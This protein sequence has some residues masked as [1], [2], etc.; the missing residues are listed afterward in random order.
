MC[1]TDVGVDAV[2]TPD[3]RGRQGRRLQRLSA[4]TVAALDG[5]AK[6]LTVDGGFKRTPL[7]RRHFVPF[8]TPAIWV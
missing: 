7:P 5:Q 4:V 1:L 8:G 3:D 6:Q 2:W